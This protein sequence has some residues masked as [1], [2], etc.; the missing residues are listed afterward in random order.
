MS[1]S[2]DD[3]DGEDLFFEE[4]PFFKPNM[5]TSSNG[6]SQGSKS[7]FESNLK[8]NSNRNFILFELKNVIYFN[9]FTY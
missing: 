7:N 1:D 9:I 4:V 6:T 5:P 8:S 3:E 2:Y